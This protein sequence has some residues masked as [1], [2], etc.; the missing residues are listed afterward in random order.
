MTYLILLGIQMLVGISYLW[1][2]QR[3]VQGIHNELLLMAAVTFRLVEKIVVEYMTLSFIPIV[4]S[5]CIK[6]IN[7]L[8]QSGFYYVY[9]WPH[10]KF[11]AI[12]F[13]NLFFLFIGLSISLFLFIYS[14]S[15]S[16]IYI[17]LVCLKKLQMN[18]GD[19]KLKHSCSRKI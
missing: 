16:S 3:Q 10:N 18:K 13:I 1:P 17:I 4:S 11:S 8:L 5:S 15:Y 9:I 7:S 14:L 6:L 2:V 12:L 19:V